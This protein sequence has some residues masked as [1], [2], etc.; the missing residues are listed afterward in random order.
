MGVN[1]KGS[2]TVVL[3]L[4]LACAP[5]AV[6]ITESAQGVVRVEPVRSSERPAAAPA[7]QA[8]IPLPAAP[9][10][11][12]HFPVT[13]APAAVRPE[14]VGAT[15][16][17]SLNLLRKTVVQVKDYY[18]DQARIEPNLMLDAIADSWARESGGALRRDGRALVTLAGDRASLPDAK[19][20]W[21]V[22]RA[23]RDLGAFLIA[24]LPAGHPLLL[25]TTA[26][27]LA[28]AAL[29]S[30][31]DP[32]SRL[33]TAADLVVSA[34]LGPY[35]RS[36]KQAAQPIPPAAPVVPITLAPYSRSANQAAKPI[37]P[38]APVVPPGI[39]LVRPGHFVQGLPAKVKAAV[40]VNAGASA[41]TVLDLRGNAGGLFDVTT[42]LIDLF[43]PSGPM[44]I[45]N[46]RTSSEV[47][48][49]SDDHSTAERV[50][51]VVL[52]DSMTS[53]GAEMV[54]GSLRESGRTVLIGEATYG[55]DLVQLQFHFADKD[56]AAEA[57]L[58][59][60]TAQVLLPGN[61]SFGGVGV[62]PDVE[63]RG[64][65]GSPEEVLPAC[66]PIGLVTAVVAQK[67]G[68]DVAMSLAAGILA[69]AKS[70]ARADLLEA[71]R[72]AV[73]H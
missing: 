16:L 72:A 13:D 26:E 24:H 62:A 46:Q 15:T 56:P 66:R 19:N 31:L 73:A 69:G 40:E 47:K 37:P 64:G 68:E 50:K 70:A 2:A 58:V 33:F 45:L 61:L 28:T 3:L 42:Q 49:A 17:Q 10:C 12:R 1:E 52:I 30:T 25:G 9:V 57:L 67:P 20:I 41:G 36:A 63:V 43:S 44:L 21:Q 29:L 23:V 32:R 59:L 11:V 14:G 18:F 35:S 27:L 65:A 38:A 4:S 34:D 55:A 54:A 8:R 7:L 53:A 22:P 60:T 48:L 39:T 6:L 5:S 51:L 71:A